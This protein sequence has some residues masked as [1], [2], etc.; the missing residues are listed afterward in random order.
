[1]SKVGTT[2][3]NETNGKSKGAKKNKQNSQR[4]FNIVS[5]VIASS[6]AI[7][8]GEIPYAFV[9]IVS[10]LKYTSSIPNYST[11]NAIALLTLFLAPA[12]DIFIYYCFNKLYRKVLN[13]YCMRI[14]K[15]CFF[16]F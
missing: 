14:F 2:A 8:F 15:F 5:M 13:G 4:V 10:A 1:M 3:G 16:C 9:T 11:V 6:F 12:F 7:V